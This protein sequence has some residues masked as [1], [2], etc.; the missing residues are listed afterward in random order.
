MSKSMRGL[1]IW[2]SLFFSLF[3]SW[4]KLMEYGL[5]PFFKSYVLWLLF[6]SL[7]FLAIA[8]LFTVLN[9]KFNLR[10]RRSLLVHS[11]TTKK[12]ERFLF[13]SVLLLMIV[14]WM[15]A[16]LAFFPG[17]FGADAP[18]QLAMYNGDLPFTTHHPWLHTLLLG[19]LLRLGNILF[20]NPNA[21]TGI[22]IFFF[23]IV[24]CA[25]AIAKAMLYLYRKG[26][27]AWILITT[28]FFMA[29]S[30]FS[31]MLVCYTT[32]DIMFAP[33]LLLFIVSICSLLFPPKPSE[34]ARADLS[35]PAENPKAVREKDRSAASSSL[36]KKTAEIIG[37]GVLMC[38][39]RNQGLY[40]AI[41][42]LILLFF[43]YLKDRKKRIVQLFMVSQV[44][45]LVLGWLLTSLV[46]S[47]A[48]I[49]I[50]N[51]RE[52]LALPIHQLAFELNRNDQIEEK[53]ISKEDEALAYSYFD[54]FT[55][56]QLDPFSADSS[57]DL[58][59]NEKFSENPGQFISLYLRVLTTDWR[60][61]IQAAAYLTA[62]Y[63]DMR[64]GEYN[65]LSV[66]TS[67]E[68]YAD[69]Q[70]IASYSLLPGYRDKLRGIAMQSATFDNCPLWL[71]F[72]DPGIT[73]YLV[74][75]LL[76]YAIFFRSKFAA[77]ACLYTV[78]YILTM[79]LGP[80]S[81]LRYSFIYTYQ[82]PFLLGVLLLSA[83]SR[84]PKKKTA[85]IKRTVRKS[86]ADPA[87]AASKAAI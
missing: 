62:P 30:P 70:H 14:T 35:S 68:D 76:G 47:I 82:W 81:L 52:M 57:K 8:F 1:W 17:T 12:Q 31:Q 72:F 51:P 32:K 26:L 16:F 18:I 49:K 53:F 33:A 41:L 55:P 79:L 29:V 63:F 20:H 2:T 19:S 21:G 3:A 59:Y 56:D 86:A 44:S 5:S 22:Y 40:L 61:A 11:S 34:S 27:N 65:A 64:Y 25:Y 9:R 43:V 80:V 38:L 48:G 66:M 45:I 28:S 74:I 7:L 69:K 13:W 67:Y 39:L 4:P 23:Q 54:D 75:F 85:R 15:P 73:L 87:A 6:Y 84:K 42:G 83:L 78:L 50:N 58:F 60:G 46:P 37:W 36:L 24:F 77:T 71:R 10:S